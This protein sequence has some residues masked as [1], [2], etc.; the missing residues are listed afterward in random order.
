MSLNQTSNARQP[1]GPGRGIEWEVLP[2]LAHLV[3]TN[4]SGPA[5]AA[6]WT[7][8]MPASLDDLRP[9]PE[10]IEA[11]PGLDVLESTEPEIFRLFFAPR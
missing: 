10:M 4:R 7:D 2:S 6:V 11:L 8:T 5:A 1:G 9:T 3:A